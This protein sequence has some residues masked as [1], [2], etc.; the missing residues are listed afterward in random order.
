MESAQ[1]RLTPLTR[2]TELLFAKVLAPDGKCLGH[3]F[4]LR[5]DTGGQETETHEGEDLILNPP[6]CDVREIIYGRRGWLATIGLMRPTKHTIRWDAVERVE[7]GQ[8]I[9]RGDAVPPQ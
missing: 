4:D 2:L 7:E 6:R 3:V 1:T 8:L 5:C 9:L